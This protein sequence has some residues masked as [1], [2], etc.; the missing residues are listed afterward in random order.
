MAFVLWW[1]SEIRSMT[2]IVLSEEKQSEHLVAMEP[3]VLFR[4]DF[5]L[6]IHQERWEI[7]WCE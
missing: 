7:L 3:I 4:L 5:T 2:Y 1:V 6:G